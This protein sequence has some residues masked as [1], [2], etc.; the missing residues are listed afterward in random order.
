M[1]APEAAG[2][3]AGM[4][5]VSDTPRPTTAVETAPNFNP[6][7]LY[8]SVQSD[9]NFVDNVDDTISWFCYVVVAQSIGIEAFVSF[10]LFFFLKAL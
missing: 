4:E 2:E 7:V 9:Y 5:R 1:A 10:A 8:A 6:T 3:V